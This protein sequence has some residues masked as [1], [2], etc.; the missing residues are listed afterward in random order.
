[1]RLTVS[2]GN[3]PQAL[4]VPGPTLSRYGR[5]LTQVAL[6]SPPLV[7]GAEAVREVFEVLLRWRHNNALIV[8]RPGA[9]K[10]A[11]VL[12]VARSLASSSVPTQ[13]GLRGLV[14]VDLRFLVAG[15]AVRG[16]LEERAAALVKEFVGYHGALIP[17]FEDLPALL[18]SANA[19]GLDLL[20]LFGPV[21]ESTEIPCL[22]TATT[23]LLSQRP[24]LLRQV[25]AS[26]QTIRLDEPGHAKT[27]DILRAMTP[28]I[29]RHHG[30][31]IAPGALEHATYLA[32]RYLTD[33]AL[34]DSAL[35]LV[36]QAAANA[37]LEDGA[38]PVEPD[39]VAAVA[40]RW[41]GIPL[42]HLLNEEATRLARLEQIL[43]QRLVGQDSA[44]TAVSHAVRRARA[45]L[46]DPNRPLGSFFF[47]GPTGVGKTELARGLAGILFQDEA[48]LVRIDMSEYME[49]HQVARL[50]GAPPG[51]VG[52]GEGGQLTEVVRQRPYSIVLL[53]EMEKAHPD[54]FNILLQIMEDGRLTDG[55]GRTVDFRQ[56]VI[57]MTS[58]LGSE[59]IVHLTEASEEVVRDRVM[60]EV[61]A[62][63]K[64]ELLNR[65]D[66]IIV[67]HRLTQAQIRQVVDIQVAR[68]QERLAEY[69][70]ELVLT[71][72]ARDWLAAEGYDIEYGARPLKRLIRRQLEDP[73]ALRV[74][75]GD[76]G[77]E[78]SRILVDADTEGLAISTV[79][80]E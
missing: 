55:Q 63:L 37:R 25:G 74:V 59:H 66:E 1:M 36:D 52:Y 4:P 32:H 51:Y 16:Q 49:R 61:K 13:L 50:I 41:T 9:G 29:E 62:K 79:C 65:I 3:R 71:L 33:R 69:G 53:D 30:V 68:L 8:G 60:A 7:G 31:V 76:L 44:V 70:I 45:H 47:L 15:A 40:A 6:T 12:E 48:A 10:S 56:T 73:L 24:D 5:D 17:V 34:P 38:A 2:H 39:A 22:S 75:S 14:E 19:G 28:E 58:N 23:E 11:L 77:N 72:E 35:S 26:F 57:I 18:S 43:H 21:L 78:Q 46:A 27:M 80:R 42:Q 54:V 64:P 67:F 20:R